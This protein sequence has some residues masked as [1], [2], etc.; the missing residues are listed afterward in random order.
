MERRADRCDLEVRR[1]ATA[2]VVNLTSLHLA[3]DGRRP[4]VD[5]TGLEKCKCQSI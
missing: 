4:W 1:P 3:D 5:R 2:K